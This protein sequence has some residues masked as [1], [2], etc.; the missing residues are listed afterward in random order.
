MEEIGWKALCPEND[1]NLIFPDN[2]G[3]FIPESCMKIDENL[4]FM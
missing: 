2:S 1:L 3:N 4:L